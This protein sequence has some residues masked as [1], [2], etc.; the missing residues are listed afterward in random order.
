MLSIKS[1]VKTAMPHF[2]GEKVLKKQTLGN[3]EN[4]VFQYICT[5]TLDFL[6]HV[7]GE[8][9]ATELFS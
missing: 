1:S 9:E 3:F 4:G 6:I 5:F 2:L 7:C 8:R